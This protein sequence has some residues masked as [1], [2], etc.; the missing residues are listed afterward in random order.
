M[1]YQD[2]FIYHTSTIKIIKKEKVM[3][4]FKVVVACLLATSV[5]WAKDYPKKPITMVVGFGVG[6]SADRM[7]RATSTPYSKNLD[8]PIKVINKKGA[9]TMLAANYILRR[10]ADGYTV[11]A[12]TFAPYLASTILTGGAKYKIEDFTM[13]NAQWFD[14]ELIAV[15]KNTPYKSVKELFDDIKV[16]PNKVKAS[17]VQGS[18]GHLLL[19]R[20]MDEYGV[21]FDNLNLVTYQGGGKARSAVAGGQVDMIVIS[22]EGSETIREFLRPLAI[23]K[24][25]RSDRWDTP[26]LKEELKPMGIEIPYFTG[27][28]RGY[29]VSTKMKEKYPKRYELLVEKLKQT[30]EDEE[31]KKSLTEAQ[32]GS[33]WVGPKES[34]KAIKESYEVFK[35]Y[36]HLIEKR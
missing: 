2:Y 3:K 5:L 28:V 22:A 25:E 1:Q 8:T 11:F 36:G 16:N 21:P 20:I 34:N 23:F 17:V 19:M 12:S 31:V 15:N 30:L 4:L 18:S 9:G 14:Y 10:P 6:G 26:I 29:A 32:I 13:I 27:S 35:K 24:P 7:A 33:D